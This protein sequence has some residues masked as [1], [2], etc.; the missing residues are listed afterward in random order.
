MKRQ[1]S[2][3][4]FY[5]AFILSITFATQALANTT[6]VS[7]AKALA[8]A[9]A[10]AQPGDEIVIEDG[11]WRDELLSIVGAGSA[12]APIHIHPETPGGLTVT[13][14]SRVR[15][16]GSY[17]VVSGMEF[18]NIEQISDWL[19][20]REDSKNHA[21]HCRVTDCLFIEDDDFD[22]GKMDSRWI[23]I[24]GSG[25]E[26]DHCHIEGK[27]SRGTSLVVWL[28]E[29]TLA[30]HHIHHNDFGH[31][32]P[33]GRNGGETIRIGDSKTHH[34]NAKCRIEF[35]HFVHCDGEAECISNKSCENLYRKNVFEE[36]RGTLSLRHGHRCQVTENVF[37]GNGVKHTGG[38]RVIGDDHI[39]TANHF[40]R[41]DGTDARG[42]LVL[43]NGIANSPDNG[44]SPVRRAIIQDNVAIECRQSVVIG[45][46]DKDSP[47]SSVA[48]QDCTFRNNIW[49]ANPK[50]AVVFEH[51]RA[52]NTVWQSN[53]ASGQ[54]LGIVP[55]PDGIIFKSGKAARLASSRTPDLGFLNAT[56]ITWSK[57]ENTKKQ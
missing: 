8:S 15:I 7:D 31:R 11:I 43:Q 42:A 45:Y 25:N 53:I 14:K 2:F 23:G 54:S 13:G 28:E 20:F 36:V 48:P 44:Y 40:D 38:V 12:A 9:V 1:H 21:H 32:P 50:S 4:S 27:K 30:G 6:I 49:I 33:L 57:F 19:Q 35:N 29:N 34:V 51:D 46:A 37:L 17:L 26:F 52:V 56:G 24:Y 16:G 10:N 18:R 22:P 41:L 3:R 39:V 47:S 55:V 5:C